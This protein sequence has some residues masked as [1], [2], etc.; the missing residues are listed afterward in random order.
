L[1]VDPYVFHDQI[2]DYVDVYD[3]WG[4]MDVDPGL[5]CYYGVNRE[6]AAHKYCK[7]IQG[8]SGALL[9]TAN[10]LAGNSNSPF[11]EI[12]DQFAQCRS[13]THSIVVQ[14]DILLRDSTHLFEDGTTDGGCFR[15]GVY[16]IVP[17]RADP[18][19]VCPAGG[20]S[21][22]LPNALAAA[23]LLV[24]LL[25]SVPL[26]ALLVACWAIGCCKRVRVP[27]CAT[28]RL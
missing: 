12:S 17:S 16:G 18:Q 23:V 1:Q 22:E 3:P 20:L 2:I 8:Y 6:R 24:T 15:A 9:M 19:R 27:C 11:L 26:V 14:A 4:N 5:T 7:P 25:L 10:G 13:L 21:R 28:A